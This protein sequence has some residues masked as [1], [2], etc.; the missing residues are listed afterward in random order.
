MLR[1]KVWS[2]R[3]VPQ[4]TRFWVAQ[5]TSVRLQVTCVSVTLVRMNQT[6]GGVLLRRWLK[7]ERRS[8]QWLADEIGEPCRNSQT[9]ISAWIIGPRPPPLAVAIAIRDITG[10][11]VD[12]WTKPAEAHRLAHKLRARNF[13]PRERSARLTASLSSAGRKVV[14]HE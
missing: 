3:H 5:S 12:E 1:C 6:Q 4:L 11:D 8:Q 13:T 14:Q 9:N 7:N 2:F 10:I